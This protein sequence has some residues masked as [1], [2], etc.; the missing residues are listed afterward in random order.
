MS[1]AP[2]IGLDGARS[3]L[4]AHL[5]RSVGALELV[6]EGNWSRCFG[7]EL[8]GRELVVRIGEQV[9]DFEKDRV[10]ATFARPGL[11]A[12]AVLSVAPVGGGRYLAV[13]ERG[14]GVA[15]ESLDQTG[16]RAT[17][18][19]LFATL[20]A[21]R[22]VDPAPAITGAGVWGPD[23]AG[24]HDTW[25]RSLLAVADDPPGRRTHGWR[26]ALASSVVG[27]ATFRAGL[28]RLAELA[29]AA[30]TERHLVHADLLNRN[31]LVAPDGSIASIFDWGC[32]MAGDHLYDLAGL[33]FWSAWYPDLAAVDVRTAAVAHLEQIGL[34][35]PDLDARLLA[36]QLHLA[37]ENLGHSA[38]L[39]LEHPLRWIES[40]LAA[41]L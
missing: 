36:C 4:E 17:L 32:S 9:D 11:P 30:P 41:L 38:W 18:P 24:R 22:S 33:V 15:L 16:W 2:A 23:G 8:G 19:S 20:D 21:L 34:D 12:P 10:A 31:V 29:D 6:G 1:P 25:R 39:G 28:V 26:A 7:F 3:L 5:G 27:D 37:L 14:H 35:V 40:Q 13:S